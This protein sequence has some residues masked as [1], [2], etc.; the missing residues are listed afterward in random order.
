MTDNRCIPQPPRA[1]AAPVNLLHGAS[2]ADSNRQL[3][4]EL[5]HENRET[6][7]GSLWT[8]EGEFGIP[9]NLHVDVSEV[10]PARD[11]G[12]DLIGKPLDVIKIRTFHGFAFFPACGEFLKQLETT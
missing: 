1:A 8:D 7:A 10:E 5:R 6:G 3:A 2:L 4:D 12:F 11:L 9:S